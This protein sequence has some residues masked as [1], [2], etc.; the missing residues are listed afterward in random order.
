M[1]TVKIIPIKFRSNLKHLHDNQ[2]GF[3]LVELMIVV[4]I[5][6]VLAAVAV[7]AFNGF[8][9][10][11]RKVEAKTTLAAIYKAQKAFRAENQ[12]YTSNL[13]QAGYT[14]EGRIRYNTGFRNIA[15]VP[16]S[17]EG[18]VTPSRQNMYVICHSAT[19][20]LDSCT[21][22]A[23]A[24]L[25]RQHGG[26]RVIIHSTTS[27]QDAFY[28]QAGGDPGAFRT[29]GTLARVLTNWWC[30]NSQK[31]L[32]EQEDIERTSNGFLNGPTVDDS[33]SPTSCSL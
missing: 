20:P 13:L 24:R 32:Q 11:S 4:A 15:F 18:A 3:S 28:I 2:S 19:P 21:L 33:S 29:T 14:P 22:T 9:Q 1:K 26:A 17:R 23:S 31:N 30:I 25:L 5:I 10:N 27:S 6:G 8:L 12:H 16:S 7:P